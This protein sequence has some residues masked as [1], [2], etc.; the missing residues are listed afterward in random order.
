MELGSSREQARGGKWP[1]S[2]EAKQAIQAPR[3]S[4]S[5][6]PGQHSRD[7]DLAFPCPQRLS[8]G[9]FPA[10]PTPLPGQG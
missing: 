2:G 7:G 10:P 8:K 4:A 9:S 6:S 5:E 1:M 3:T